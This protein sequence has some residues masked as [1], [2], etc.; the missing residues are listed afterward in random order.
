[1]EEVGPR[2]PGPEFVVSAAEF[3]LEA[4]AKR[5]GTKLAIFDEQ[6]AAR[7]AGHRVVLER[8]PDAIS[9]GELQ[10]FF[11]IADRI[12]DRAG[13]GLRGACALVVRRAVHS[14]T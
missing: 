6:M 11:P 4:T 9:S 12:A 1:M 13:G 2:R 5:S 3:T 10:V 14:D 8:L 7:H